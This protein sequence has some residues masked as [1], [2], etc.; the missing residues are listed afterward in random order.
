VNAETAV[1]NEARIRQIHD[2]KGL[3]YGRILPTNIDCFFDFGNRLFVAIEFKTNGNEMA[4]G[5]RWA[6]EHL[7]DAS[8]V[9]F[10]FAEAEHHHPADEAIDCGQA[11]VTRYRYNGRWHDVDERMT[12]R[13][14]VNRMK[15]RHLR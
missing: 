8:R 12:C 6:F 3:R 1:Y 13:Q 9:P 7:C 4:F 2:F 14:F 5:Q 11:T 15:R 10:V